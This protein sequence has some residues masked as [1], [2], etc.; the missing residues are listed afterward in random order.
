MERFIAEG[1]SVELSS[2]LHM[3]DAELGWEWWLGSEVSLRLGLGWAYTVSA[4]AELDVSI[5]PSN[6]QE[7]EVVGLIE[8]EGSRQ[9]GELYTSFF[10]PPS[11][12][13]A[14]GFRF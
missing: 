8:Q 2:T 5:E 9:L 4:S 11:L 14:L 12:N 13:V 7:E 6:A 3:L 1:A 10:H